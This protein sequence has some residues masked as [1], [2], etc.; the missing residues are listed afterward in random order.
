ML[1]YNGN[2][3]SAIPFRRVTGQYLAKNRCSKRARAQ[4]AADI[5]AGKVM[6]SGLTIKQLAALCRVSVPYVTEARNRARRPDY[7]TRLARA[8]QVA[9]SDQRIQFIRRAGPERIF[10]ATV[11]AIG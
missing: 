1:T 8:W 11:Q 10:D 4:L 9:D 6:V 2:S 7:A 3:N 5:L